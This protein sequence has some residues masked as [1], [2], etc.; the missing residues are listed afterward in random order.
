MSVNI[1]RPEFTG[2][3]VDTDIPVSVATSIQHLDPE[4]TLELV[5][6]A[7]GELIDYELAVVLGLEGSEVLRV[8][9]T[10]G[11]LAGPGLK[12]FAIVLRN[13]RDLV[14]IMEKGEPKLFGETE[15]H[16]D[17]YDGVLDLPHG[18]SCLVAPLSCGG[19]SIGLLTLDHR[20][21][22]KFTPGV[23]RF[24]ATISKLISI[25]MIQSDAASEL[26]HANANL[27]RERNA[28][29]T[30]GYE[31]LT[32]L[33]GSS[34]AWIRAIE[35]IRM[36]AGT[37]LPVLVLGETGT[38]KE[39]ASR[40]IHRLS[41]R[42][43]QPFVAVNCSALAPS[44][45]ESELFGHE[46]GAFTGAS[47]S[48]KGRFELADGGTLFLDEIGD[49]PMELQP[50]LLRIIQEGTFERV[51]S[52]RTIRVN[53]RIV[54][55]THVDLA[56]A[57]RNGRFREDLYY[58]LSVFPVH[59]PALR[60]RP[61][62][63]LL[64]AETFLADI[65]S[66]PGFSGTALSVEAARVLEERQ[67]PGNVR[68]LRNALERGAI[69]ARGNLI[70]ETHV[71]LPLVSDH[72]QKNQDHRHRQN[73]N[74]QDQVGLADPATSGTE[75]IAGTH[76]KPAV[77]N[78]VLSTDST[79][80]TLTIDDAQRA[81]IRSALQQSGGRIYGRGGAAELLGLKPSTLQSRM[82]KLGITAQR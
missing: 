74:P 18:H 19:K 78:R 63:I 12:D 79:H 11:P 44:L 48:R 57:A 64:L 9:K 71:A 2:I 38:G 43:D 13:R 37:E 6:E 59:L 23:V 15:D 5:L 70:S 62:D 55:A 28:L 65:R 24:I 27:V 4:H 26:V 54:A 16:V 33:V 25:S 17:T 46:K 22:G 7:L 60:Y 53:V 34:P 75:Q 76:R 72:D 73:Q 82:K 69:L 50:K 10:A 81:A 68:E 66:R 77:L 52:E 39:L 21:C 30:P 31:P 14:H 67:W 1:R 61:G 45:A 41:T 8:R 29:L 47:S 32:G 20:T 42:A 80:T 58:R 3:S 40:S 56:E 49:L 51:G 35:A 36:V